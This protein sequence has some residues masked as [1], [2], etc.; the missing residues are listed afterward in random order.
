M[1]GLILNKC[2]WYLD[3]HPVIWIVNCQLQ[4]DSILYWSAN[5]LMK[6]T[7]STIHLNKDTM[8]RTLLKKHNFDWNK[9][10]NSFVYNYDDRINCFNNL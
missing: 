5:L 9:I 7:K 6:L 10:L 8:S 4:K 1:H 3:H 2:E